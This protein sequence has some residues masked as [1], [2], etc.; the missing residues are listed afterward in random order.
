MKTLFNSKTFRILKALKS[1]MRFMLSL[2]VW[3][4]IL[5]QSSN[6]H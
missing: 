1:S 5:P 3:R 4:L 6:L 2:N